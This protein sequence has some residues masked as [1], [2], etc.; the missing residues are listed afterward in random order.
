MR[1]PTPAR[2]VSH[3]QTGAETSKCELEIPMGASA[4]NTETVQPKTAIAE[5]FAEMFT[6]LRECKDAEE[7]RAAGKAIESALY[8]TDRALRAV[9]A[10]LDSTLDEIGLQEPVTEEQHA[11]LDGAN[12]LVHRAAAWHA[13]VINFADPAIRAVADL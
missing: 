3:H 9:A 8:D 5:A 2:M 13:K 1:H 11:I 6:P 4:K 12:L 7:R 10:I